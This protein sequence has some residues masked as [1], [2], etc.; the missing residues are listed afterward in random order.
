MG[1]GKSSRIP[2]PE[3]GRK[4]GCPELLEGKL[5]EQLFRGGVGNGPPSSALFSQQPTTA[6]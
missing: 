5:H 6:V 3:E 2:E 4:G 1:T